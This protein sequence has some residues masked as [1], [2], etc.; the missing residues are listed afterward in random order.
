MNQS[1]NW[2]SKLI[3]TGTLA[4]AVFGFATAYMMARD[5]E[6]SG[7]E[8]N[9]TSGDLMK[10]APGVIAIMRTLTALGK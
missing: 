1:S 3:L 6:K 2:K 8:L 4:G 10:A 9:L 5:A 7:G